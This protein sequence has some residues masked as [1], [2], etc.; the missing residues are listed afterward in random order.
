MHLQAPPT[1]C[2][3]PKT[4]HFIHHRFSSVHGS[5]AGSNLPVSYVGFAW[6]FSKDEHLKLI[7]ASKLAIGVSVEGF[8]V[9][10]C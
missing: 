7:S 1:N 8:S 2:K 6:I 4:L 9:S 5:A 10:L 3:Q